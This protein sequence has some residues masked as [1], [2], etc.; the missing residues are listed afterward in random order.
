M[1]KRYDRTKFQM[2]VVCIGKRQ[3]LGELYDDF[4][5]SNAKI[6][7]VSIKNPIIFSIRLYQLLKN[8]YQVLMVH[9]DQKYSIPI[10]LI[11]IVTGIKCRIKAYH[12]T[13]IKTSVSNW[14]VNKIVYFLSTTITGCSKTTLDNNFQGWQKKSKFKMLYYG[15]DIEKYLNV[16]QDSDVRLEFGIGSNDFII[17][18][19]SRFD[20]QKNTSTIC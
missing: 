6:Y 15:V 2:D 4:L 18:N 16:E 3:D 20:P 19:I 11:G 10:L 7:Y 14:L 1:F 9:V 12:N 8:S 17:G 5:R 13:K